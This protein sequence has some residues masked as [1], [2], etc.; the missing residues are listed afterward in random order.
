M[1]LPMIVA[2]CGVGV[3]VACNR[4]QPSAAQIK[5]ASVERSV[6]TDSAFHVDRCEP[7]KPGE[8]W[9]KVCTPKDQG[10]EIGRKK[11]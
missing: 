4:A 7:V 1:R 11:P 8:N 10:V 9:R 5:T 6:F 2:A 3:T